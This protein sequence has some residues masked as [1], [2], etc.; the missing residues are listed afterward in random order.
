MTM[1]DTDT[2]R[3]DTDVHDIVGRIIDLNNMFLRY[4]ASDR[5]NQ[6]EDSIL[7][8]NQSEAQ[9]GPCVA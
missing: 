5:T 9:V 6:S 1:V 3:D 4:Q 2:G 8:G 7:E